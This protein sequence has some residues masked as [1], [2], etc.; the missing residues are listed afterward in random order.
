[1][2][3]T[4]WILA[5][6]LLLVGERLIFR[7]A[8]LCLFC[9]LLLLVVAFVFIFII[10]VEIVFVVVVLVIVV[11]TIVILILRVILRNLARLIML[12]LTL[13]STVTRISAM[14]LATTLASMAAPMLGTDWLCR[15]LS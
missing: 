8:F 7:V 1:M 3:G 14:G 4:C 11:F 9:I 15:L 5:P 13:L 12:R 2:V 6:I 10:I